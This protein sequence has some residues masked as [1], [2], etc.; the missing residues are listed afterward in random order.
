MQNE[1]Y[2]NRFGYIKLL[3]ADRSKWVVI[4]CNL[5]ANHA[6]I[7]NHANLL[8]ICYRILQS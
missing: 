7:D 4:V 3:F 8:R 2:I 5:R 6:F 1:Q